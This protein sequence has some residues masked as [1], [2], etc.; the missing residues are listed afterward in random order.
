MFRFVKLNKAK[1]LKCGDIIVSP[2]ENASANITCSCGHLVISGGATALVRKGE[3]GTDFEEMSKL[4]FDGECPAV[5][6]DIQDPP[7]EQEMLLQ[8][9]KN[10]HQRK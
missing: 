2:Q 5:R 6:E 8:E 1:C 9:L 4:V 3:Q 7:P 10:K